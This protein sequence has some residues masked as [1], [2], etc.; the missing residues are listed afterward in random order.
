MKIKLII[1]LLFCALYSKA[2][3]DDTLFFNSHREAMNYLYSDIDSNKIPTK[4]F[5]DRAPY[6]SKLLSADGAKT[7]SSFNYFE[8]LFVY[9]IIRESHIN[10]T[11]LINP[12]LLDTGIRSIFNNSIYLGIL[13]FNCNRFK[14]SVYLLNQISINQGKIQDNT[15]ASSPIKFQKLF[16]SALLT[17]SIEAGNVNYVKYSSEF[18]F[19][20][21]TIIISKTLVNFSD[22]NGFQEI[23]FND[24]KTVFYQNAGIYDII[25]KQIST[26]GDT[27]VSLSNVLVWEDNTKFQKSILRDDLSEP[28]AIYTV[29]KNGIQAEIGIWF[30]CGNGSGHLRKPLIMSAGFNPA[31]GKA[32]SPGRLAGLGVPAGWVF[33]GWRGTYFETYDGTYLDASRQ[34]YIEGHDNGNW[35]LKRMMEEGFDI[36]VVA[37]LEGT[38]YLSNNAQAFEAA[39]AWVNTDK[40]MSLSPKGEPNNYENT[41]VGYSAGG[42][43]TRYALSE[44]EKN[45]NVQQWFSLHHHTRTWVSFE[46]EHQGANTPLGIQYFQYYM[47]SFNTINA[48][49]LINSITC[50]L[51]WNSATATKTARTLNSLNIEPILGTI[52]PGGYISA[53]N[54]HNDFFNSLRALRPNSNPTLAGYPLYCRRIGISQGS[55]KAINT[56]ELS[57]W[58]DLLMDYKINSI[59]GYVPV[60]GVPIPIIIRKKATAYFQKALYPITSDLIFKYDYDIRVGLFT[61]YSVVNSTIPKNVITVAMPYDKAPGGLQQAH[62]QQYNKMIGYP[63]LPFSTGFTIPFLETTKA[64]HSFTPTVSCLDLH[65]P[66]HTYLDKEFLN[67]SPVG[68]GLMKKQNGSPLVPSLRENYGF[69]HIAYPNNHYN[70]TPFDAIWAVGIPADDRSNQA[71]EFHVEDPDVQIG[72]FLQDEIASETQYLSNRIIGG[73]YEYKADF[74]ARHDIVCGYDIYSNHP[75]G[76]PAANGNFIVNSNADVNFKAARHITL[77]P[78]FSAK[79]GSRFTAYIDDFLCLPNVLLRT[80]NLPLADS[81]LVDPFTAKKNEPILYNYVPKNNQFEF[82]KVPKNE[83]IITLYPNPANS[84][85]YLKADA[86]IKYFIVISNTLGETILK[87]KINGNEKL[88]VSMLSNGY[89]TVTINDENTHVNVKLIVY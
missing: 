70:I 62:L 45:Y 14:D 67:V 39:I 17:D 6:F 60:Y 32:L 12:V 3:N 83:S 25:V 51:G 2:Q 36:V 22:G 81:S 43:A 40:R 69:P 85:I 8:W 13:N 1:L 80:S 35:F 68:L 4:I 28:D 11:Q 86:G 9:N 74:E 21:D 56:Q 78:G 20:N 72:K 23:N 63:Y 54:E 42:L 59:L 64:N 37:Y 66:T 75:L 84:Y 34:G 15:G 57:S 50:N 31:S 82:N 27:L 55:A 29:E 16:L 24:S 71:N 7:D 38:D 77:K 49:D 73:S 58:N 41:I 26:K 30:G 44:M 10:E 53:G 19:S 33:A 89:Y 18:C 61:V 46:G 79:S 5:L 88:D 87:T 47:K 76:Q 65:D 52:T 48:F